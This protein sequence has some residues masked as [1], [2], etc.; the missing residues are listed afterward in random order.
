MNIN[1][2]IKYM[3][4]LILILFPLFAFIIYNYFWCIIQNTSMRISIEHI[5]IFEDYKMLIFN[6]KN[7][8]FS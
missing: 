3:Y 4:I 8:L 2:C 1:I 5:Y 7:I 6:I